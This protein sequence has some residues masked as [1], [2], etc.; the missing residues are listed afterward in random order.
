MCVTKSL[1]IVCFCLKW[2][3]STDEEGRT[4][5]YN[6][7]NSESAWELPQVSIFFIMF[8]SDLYICEGDIN[9]LILDFVSL[10]F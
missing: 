2:F 10:T 9:L 6:S 7:D 3:R 5:F 1:V 8:T 4:Y